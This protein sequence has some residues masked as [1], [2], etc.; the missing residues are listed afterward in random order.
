MRWVIALLLLLPS[1][2]FAQVPVTT[3][4][5]GDHVSKDT[6]REWYLKRAKDQ[7]PMRKPLLRVGSEMREGEIGA[8]PYLNGFD[9]KEVP[10]PFVKTAVLQVLSDDSQLLSVEMFG[11][12]NRP[13]PPTRYWEPELARTAVV[14]V[15]GMSTRGVA[16]GDR[17][18]LPGEWIVSG[19]DSYES[20]GGKRTVMAI[21][22]FNDSAIRDAESEAL[23]L[24][25]AE[26][27]KR[28][29]AATKA[30]EDEAT[31]AAQKQQGEREKAAHLARIEAE[32]LAAEKKARQRVWTSA[33]GRF[34]VEAEF[35]S[36]GAGKLRL[37]RL[38]NG[39]EIS[40]EENII[41]PADLAWIK[42]RRK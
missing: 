28:I 11:W 15:K 33:D 9:P 18:K 41:S 38:D 34:K 37:R 21:T 39:K 25:A 13:G 19:T 1:A 27:A 4:D 5:L 35:L 29:E 3:A 22:P 32:Q 20:R 36:Y 16:D 12:Q 42:A 6:V 8:L 31:A 10:L 40:M 30:A 24:A 26:S 2:A 23:K 17:V 7:Q 14:M